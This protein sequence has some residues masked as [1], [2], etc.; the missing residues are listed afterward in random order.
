MKLHRSGNPVHDRQHPLHLHPDGAE[1]EEEEDHHLVH[2]PGL[3][4]LHGHRI[5]HSRYH[6][7]KFFFSFQDIFNNYW[8]IHD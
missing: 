6:Y 2:Q 4:R 5:C 8:H 1:D 3:G 7:D